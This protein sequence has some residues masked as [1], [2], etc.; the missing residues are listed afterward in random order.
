[1]RVSSWLRKCRYI[2]VE[3]NL[4][5]ESNVDVSEYVRLHFTL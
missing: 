2:C 4:K 5:N 1:M 3:Q